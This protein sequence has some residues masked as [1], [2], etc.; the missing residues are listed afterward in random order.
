MILS[1]SL[2]RLND[3]ETAM[4]VLRP[5]LASD[6]PDA[7]ALSLMGTAEALRGNTEADV[8]YLDKAVASSPDDAAL[9]SQL[10]LVRIAAGT[11]SEER[12]VVNECFSTC[13]DRWSA[14][15]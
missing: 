9:R 12:R 7:R 2:L 4:T 11:R 13:K 14:S 6:A 10:G 1:A 15:S 8:Q 3:A 5:L